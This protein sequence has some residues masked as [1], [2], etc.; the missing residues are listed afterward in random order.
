MNFVEFL[1]IES[2]CVVMLFF[3][4]YMYIKIYVRV[5]FFIGRMFVNDYCWCSSCVHF[6]QWPLLLVKN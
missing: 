4:I 1:N 2:M 5:G 6:P 3:Y